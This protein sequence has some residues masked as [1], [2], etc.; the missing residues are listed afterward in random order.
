VYERYTEQARQ[1][2][3]LAQEEARLMQHSHVGTEH[4]L[5]GIA[6]L[7]D[8]A[9]AHALR[10]QGLDL[11]RT[12]AEVVRHVPVGDHVESGEIPLTAAAKGALDVAL[13]EALGLGHDAVAPG[14]LLLGVL[15]QADGVARRILVEAAGD[16]HTVR[17]TIVT[18]I[19][20]AAPMRLPL[21]EP[22]PEEDAQLLLTIL[23]RGGHAAVLLR[24]R[25]I[26]EDAVRKLLGHP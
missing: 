10:K 17:E 1:V 22:P 18:A 5:L 21:G 23:A 6:R 19:G 12:R 13:R 9:A 20:Q 15:R 26:D 4:L 11:Q 24:S 7:E 8:D 2:I 3:V 14:H 25:G 16:V